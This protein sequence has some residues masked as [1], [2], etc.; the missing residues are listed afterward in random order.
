MGDAREL[1]PPR[2]GRRAGVISSILC[3]S[4]VACAQADGAQPAHRRTLF[5]LGRAAS[6]AE[7][8][9]LDIDVNPA[10]F[11]LPPGRGTS[12]TGEATYALKCTACHGPAGEGIAPNPRLIGNDP[13]AGFAFAGD[14][15]APK[16]IG[17]YWPYA[18]TLYDYLR[19]AMPLTAPGSLTP[20]ETYGLVAFL[21]NRNGIVPA[22]MVIDAKSL[23]GVV[24]PARRYFVRDNRTGGRTFR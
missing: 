11:G 9:A 17:N 7:I 23:P 6:A 19:R 5:G 16:T 2:R 21:L 20:D 4:I 22:T 13:A 1:R 10:G 8:A 18:T 3:I 14:A 15:K 24:M 12:A